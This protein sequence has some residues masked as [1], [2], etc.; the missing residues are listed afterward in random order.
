MVISCEQV[1][2][3]VSNYLEG[4]INPEVRSAMEEHLRGCKHCTAVVDGTRNVVQL[5]GDER[6]LEVPL[7]F[8]QRLHRRIAQSMPAPRGNFLGWT[9]AAAAALLLVG[10]LSIGNFVGSK[11]PT[12]RSA[13][14]RPAAPTIPAEMKVVVYGDGKTFHTPQCTFIHDRNQARTMTASEALRE[15]FTPC[16]RCMRQYL[17]RTALYS[18]QHYEA[19][20]SLQWNWTFP[21]SIGNRWFDEHSPFANE[22]GAGE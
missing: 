2:G 10:A 18:I 19:E 3:E 15:G 16:V 12:A 22:A 13:L 20:A 11:N 7:G 1:W 5:Y 4:D 8:N 14:A 6:M 17:G 9:L 21:G